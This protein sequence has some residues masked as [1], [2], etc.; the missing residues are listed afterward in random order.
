MKTLLVKWCFSSPHGLQDLFGSVVRSSFHLRIPF[1]A[2]AA[3]RTPFVN[4]CPVLGLVAPRLSKAILL[5]WHSIGLAI[6]SSLAGSFFQQA[7][8]VES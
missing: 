3:F 4:F 1:F 6:G 8:C 7:R 2:V 5:A